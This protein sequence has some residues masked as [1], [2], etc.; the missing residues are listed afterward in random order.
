MEQ[1]PTLQEL[2]EIIKRERANWDSLVEQIDQERMS[3]PG[4][5]GQW[6]VKDII[7]HITWHE[8]E[9]VGLVR[10][11]ALVGSEL[12]NLPT[13][14]RNAAIYRE[15]R[16]QPLE[17][18]L[19]ESAQVFQELL[20]V[21]PSLTDQDLTDPGS[22]PN[23]PPDW[24]PWVILAQNTYEHYQDHIPDVQRWIDEGK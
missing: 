10:A 12:W 16:D 21:L 5:A 19:E 22:F 7:A 1:P 6:S 23:M 17:Q 14:E 3:Q 24:Q 2:I 20:A 13:N 9:M 15:V 8:R 18:V 4:V 11:H